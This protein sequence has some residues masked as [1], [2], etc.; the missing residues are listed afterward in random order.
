VD[1]GDLGSGA[2][3]PTTWGTNLKLEFP[4]V[5]A[6]VKKKDRRKNKGGDSAGVTK[7]GNVDSIM[8]SCIAE[9][10]LRKK[11]LM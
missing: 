11:G 2:T 10:I 8:T 6:V 7:V 1:Q 3:K 5:G 4:K 9:T